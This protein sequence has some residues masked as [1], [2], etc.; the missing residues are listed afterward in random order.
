MAPTGKSTYSGGWKTAPRTPDIYRRWAII[1]SEAGMQVLTYST[2]CKHLR[3][4]SS[5]QPAHQTLVTDIATITLFKGP[6]YTVIGLWAQ[7][8]TVLWPTGLIHDMR[9]RVKI[10]TWTINAVMP[11]LPSRHGNNRQEYE[12]TQKTE[13][14]TTRLKRKTVKHTINMHFSRNS[15]TEVKTRLK[16]K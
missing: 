14:K 1:R 12:H 4:N 11:I 8:S 16:R 9:R 6:R 7:S 13:Q 15:Q 3:R 2:P 5:L 10:S